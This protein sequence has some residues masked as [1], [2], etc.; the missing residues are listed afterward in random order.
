MAHAI[1]FTSADA[2]ESERW[3]GFLYEGKTRLP[4]IFPAPTKAVALR[5]AEAFWTA[6][7]AKEAAKRELAARMSVRRKGER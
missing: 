3:V 6:E 2:P 4:V 1:A 5:S 7:K